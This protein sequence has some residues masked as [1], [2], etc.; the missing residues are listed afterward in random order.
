LENPSLWKLTDFGISVLTTGY[1]MATRDN[2]GTDE[3]TAPEILHAQRDVPTY[4][5]A[6]DIFG[7]GLI[8][9]ELFTGHRVFYSRADA[10]KY[11]P[12]IP[13]LYYCPLIPVV[14]PFTP[15]SE[16][17]S[18]YATQVVLTPFDHIDDNVRIQ[19]AEFWDAVK[20]MEL[21]NKAFL[22]EVNSTI[23][24]RLE[25]INTLLRAMLDCNP[26]KRPTIDVLEHHFRANT[27][28][29]MLEN[30]VV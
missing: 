21:T 9:H 17:A 25:E 30:D 24:S 26:A 19:L 7:I 29:S 22:G 3:Y 27:I 23:K 5:N 1:M 18:A 8:L 13:Q 10:M 15:V 11:P 2:R 20:S 14:G 28:R 12:I 6:V 16:V 4:W